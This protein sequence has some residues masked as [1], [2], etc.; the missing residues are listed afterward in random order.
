MAKNSSALG[1]YRPFLLLGGLVL[2]AATLQWAQKVVV[3]VT[4][5]VLL[6]FVLAPLVT[7]FQRRGLPRVPAALVVVLLALLVVAALGAGLTLQA[8]RLAGELPQYRE[9]IARKVAGVRGLGQ[10]GW[11]RNL[12]D[13]FRVVTGGAQAEGVPAGEVPA[14]EL[15]PGAVAP[16]DGPPPAAAE[17]RPVP[18]RVESSVLPD[19]EQLL[20]PAAEFLAAAGLVVVLVT[21]MLIRREDLRNR[22]MRLVPAGR[23]L[24]TTRALT[25]AAERLSRFLLVQLAVNAACGAVL[26]VGLALI[27][28]PYALVWGILAAFLRY[29]PYVGTALAVGLV[30]LFAVAVFPGWTQPLLVLALFAAVEL[31]A[32]NVVEPLLFGHSTGVSPLA[33]LVALAFWT[34][35]WGPV[36]LV[37]STPLTVCLLVLGRHLPG[38]EALGVLLGDEPPPDPEINFYQRLLA[39]DQD[40][41][42]ALVDQFAAAHP[43][44]EVFDGLLL[45]ALGLARADRAGDE[46][47]PEAE[48]AICRAAR[49]ILDYLAASA[50]ADPDADEERAAGA[51][52]RRC[53]ALGYPARDE[54]EELSLRMLAQLLDASGCRLEVLAA[55]TDAAALAARVRRERPAVLVVGVLP[56]GGM[57]QAQYL[58]KRLRATS[59]G[60]K[61]LVGLWG[62]GDDREALAERLRSGGADAVAGSLAE[63]RDR[64]LALVRHSATSGDAPTTPAAGAAR[65]PAGADAAADAPGNGVVG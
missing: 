45:P 14:P 48:H 26:A 3:P 24:L 28:L 25:E 27:G 38:L 7:F 34:W 55:G 4:L 64:V 36:G 62:V 59:P 42:T 44:E 12:R 54:A 50:Q 11:L 63:A 56:P 51:P 17:P 10:S 43:P 61:L 37:L 32:A 2:V 57:A 1:P 30:T 13:T 47:T 31:T 33:L 60:L 19:Y 39:G 41:A 46:L 40:E 53:V 23:L 22:L 21:F 5:A 15:P 35:L 29:L 16:P 52:A 6:A 58:C 49:D 65:R 9:N 20:G 8:R 18:V